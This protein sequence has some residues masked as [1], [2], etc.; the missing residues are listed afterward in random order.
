MP[1]CPVCGKETVDTTRC[2]ENICDGFYSITVPPHLHL[3]K[4]KLIGNGDCYV[5]FDDRGKIYYY[6]DFRN[7]DIDKNDDRVGIGLDMRFL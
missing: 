4:S 3:C 5:I 6:L 7:F 2:W 1:K